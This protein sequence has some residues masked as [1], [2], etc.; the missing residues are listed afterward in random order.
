MP[1]WAAELSQPL[2]PLL[3]TLLVTG[4]DTVSGF[5]DLHFPIPPQYRLTLTEPL[6]P[7]VTFASWRGRDTVAMPL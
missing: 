4:L 1:A 6:T 5:P 2:A 3:L 7:E